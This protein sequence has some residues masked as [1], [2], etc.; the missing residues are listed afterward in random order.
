MTP[1]EIIQ[2]FMAE[3]NANNYTSDTAGVGTLILDNAVRGSS[4]FTSTQAVINQMLV[5]QQ[6]AER[7]AIKYVLGDKY[8]S[9]FDGKQLSEISLPVVTWDEV[10]DKTAYGFDDIRGN[11]FLTNRFEYTL[12]NIIKENT[13]RIFLE[14]YCG[15]Q[16]NTDYVLH[17][18][19]FTGYGLEGLMINDEYVSN[20]TIGTPNDD[21]G[22]ITGS[23]A[24]LAFKVGDTVND[25]VLTADN[26]TAL[27]S[28]YGDK[29]SLSSDGQTLVIGTGVEKTE[30]SIVPEDGDIY[31]FTAQG[32]AKNINTGSNG[33]VVSATTGNDTITSGGRDSINAGTGND[34][35]TVSGDDATVTTGNGNDTVEISASVKSVT[36]T[37]LDS[38]DTISIS[39]TFEV[40]NAQIENSMLVVTDKTGKRK[41]KFSDLTNAGNAKIGSQKINADNLIIR[42][43]NQMALD[44]SGVDCDL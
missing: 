8:N 13:A 18:T 2:T 3:L 37:D 27:K 7:E 20:K 5:D 41:I 44:L 17:I 26:L 9:S 1:Q 35:I 10:K 19:G 14:K 38:S 40:G 28:K 21:T 12:T 24:N 36:I 31:L 34:K 25:S 32:S 39:G 4:K 43:H 30:T 23:D 15:I 42:A 33:W 11:Y 6:A 29:A 22:A 16:L